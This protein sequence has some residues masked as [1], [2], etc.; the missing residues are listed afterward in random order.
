MLPGDGV[1]IAA[2][3]GGPEDGVPVVFLHGAGQTR[4]SW[5]QATARLAGQGY[6]VCSLDLRGHG[7]SGWAADGDYRF[8]RF[9]ADL[10]GVLSLLDRPAF[11]VGAS[12]GGLTAMLTIGEGHAP[13]AGLVL[14]DI[15]P[16]IEMAGAAHIGGF[17]RGNPHGFASLDEAADVVAAFRPHRPRP[18]D[19][20]GLL[21]NLR[22]RDD[23]RYYWHWDP[24]FMAGSSQAGDVD[25]ATERLQRAA[26]GLAVPTKLVRGAL[27]NM[28][29]DE[30]VAEFRELVPHAEVQVIEAADHMVAGDRN[31]RFTEAVIGFLDRHAHAAAAPDAKGQPRRDGPSGTGLQG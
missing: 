16:R 10:A 2:D 7:E 4:F 29:S 13:A 22:L 24:V 11:V 31:D 3:L 6:R 1:E 20:S 25:E 15:A 9:I 14:V 26:A 17:M 8:D 30:S 27:S 5:G 19:T 18:R 23:G 12:M 21:K 28:V